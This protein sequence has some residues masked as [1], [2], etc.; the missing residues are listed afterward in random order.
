[1]GVDEMDLVYVLLRTPKIL[2]QLEIDP[3]ASLNRS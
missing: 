3:P 1:M 2:C